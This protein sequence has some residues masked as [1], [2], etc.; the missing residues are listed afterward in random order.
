MACSFKV[1]LCPICNHGGL[2][3]SEKMIW[4]RGGQKR[5]R[6]TSLRSG[7]RSR[8]KT[9]LSKC[10]SYSREDNSNDDGAIIIYLIHYT[11]VKL[12]DLKKKFGIQYATTNHIPGTYIR[13]DP[14][15][16]YSYFTKTHWRSINRR[17][18]E[19]SCCICEIDI[20]LSVLQH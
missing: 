18:W 7:R 13:N 9:G 10:S 2:T 3:I 14:D 6:I 5:L 16:G 20:I 17:V 12:M 1:Y 19:C 4:K 15:M 11:G 8:Q